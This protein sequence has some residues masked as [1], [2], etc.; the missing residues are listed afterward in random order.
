MLLDDALAATKLSNQWELEDLAKHAPP[1]PRRGASARSVKQYEE[2]VAYHRQRLA[3]AKASHGQALAAAQVRA[4]VEDQIAAQFAATG[5]KVS[6]APGVFFSEGLMSA[7]FLNAEQGTN[8]RGERY[9][10]CLGG[11]PR[12]ERAF[13][14]ALEGLGTGISRV[15]MLDRSF[16][17][18]TLELAGGLSCRCKAE[19]EL[20][21]KQLASEAR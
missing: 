4:K 3:E 17:R 6:R 15:H 9:Y 5:L 21:Q 7:N 1:P 19:G 20:P 14:S 2:A 13:L 11:D 8:L 10:I 16:T 18:A 12:A